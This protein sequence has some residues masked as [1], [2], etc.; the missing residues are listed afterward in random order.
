MVVLYKSSNGPTEIGASWATTSM[1]K[2]LVIILARVLPFRVT[3]RLLLLVP[4][5]TMRTEVFLAMYE[6]S[7]GRMGRG[8]SW[9]MTSME[10]NPFFHF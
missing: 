6:S 10:K 1:E 4:Q 9:E 3:D 2:R 5:G 8:R 7:N